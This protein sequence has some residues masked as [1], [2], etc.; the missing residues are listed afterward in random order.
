MAVRHIAAN[1]LSVLIVAGLVVAVAFV[2]AQSEFAEPGPLKEQ[3]TVEIPRGAGLREVSQLL[4]RRG[5]I[6]SD[7]LFRLGARYSGHAQ[8]LKFGEYAFE[9]AASMQEVLQKLATGDVVMH[10]VTV[11][12]GKTSWE[13]VQILRDHPLLTGD[14]EVPDEGSVFPDTYNIQ[15]N[16][17]RRE[18]I[19]RMQTAMEEKLAAAWADRQ[20]GLPIET[21]EEALVLASIVEKE[22]GLAEERPQ[23]AA[24]FINRLRK[25]MKLQSDP[26]VVYGVTGGKGPLGRG[27]R[28]SELDRHTPYNTYAIEGLPPGPIANPGLDAIEAVLNPAETEALYFVADGTGGHAF[29]ET[30]S[31]HNA[32][33][34]RWRKIEAERQAAAEQA[35]RQSAG[36]MQ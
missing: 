25:G 1:A 7:W 17:A 36:E 21:P 28:R 23:V 4:A 9:P 8:D 13:V 15:R 29:A 26:T 24:V 19:A 12:E 5:V 10:F 20:E 16:Q 18:V 14:V 30:L 2:W 22:T 35:E 31:E 6:D 27:L 11:P 3:A 32:N 34:R 33:V